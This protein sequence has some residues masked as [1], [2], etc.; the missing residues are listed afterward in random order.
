MTLPLEKY[1]D[2]NFCGLVALYE[3][4]DFEPFLEA[5]KS[6]RDFYTGLGIALFQRC[7]ISAEVWMK[8]LLQGTLNRRDVP[9]LY[10]L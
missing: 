8:Y 4:L 5:L 3:N 2:A 10:A 1:R 7:G 9:G 6:M